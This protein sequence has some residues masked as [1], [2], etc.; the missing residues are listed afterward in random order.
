MATQ[1]NDC[2]DNVSTIINTSQYIIF[3]TRNQPNNS[4]HYYLDRR[5][6]LDARMLILNAIAVSLRLSLIAPA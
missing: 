4:C 2:T 5:H 6:P 3:V 1:R